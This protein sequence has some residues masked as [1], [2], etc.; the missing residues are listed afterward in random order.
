M[1]K[2]IKAAL[3]ATLILYSHQPTLAQT[4]IT[5]PDYEEEQEINH[6]A[7]VTLS[8]FRGA[9]GELCGVYESLGA[10]C[11]FNYFADTV[12]FKYQGQS[13]GTAKIRDLFK[14]SADKHYT[15]IMPMVSAQNRVDYNP[16]SIV[17]NYEESRHWSPEGAT[18]FLGSF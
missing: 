4:L 14:L 2:R 8:D 13:H 10:D 12:E 9:L 1:L 11:V 6:P 18:V 16:E 7:G 5:P 3:A 15:T 17:A